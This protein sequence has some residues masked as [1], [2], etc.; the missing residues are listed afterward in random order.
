[1]PAEDPNNAT[2]PGVR[3]H[4]DAILHPHR[5]LP[6]RGWTVVMGVVGA[7]SLTIGLV[8]MLQG[9]WPVMGFL[10]LDV[11]LVW[12]AFRW[13]YRSAELYETVRLTDEAL[14]VWRIDPRH[15]PRAWR[16]EP[17][18][19]RVGMDDPPRH[20]SQVTLSSHGQSLVIGAFLTPDER[21]AFAKT[22]RAALAD[23]R[24]TL[25]PP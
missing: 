13:N 23:W 9:A 8:F 7:A 25:P 18:W 15:E 1:M 6:M 3:V 17:T 4:F 16:F 5:S 21:L 22:L 2:H 20:T 19:L 24:R 10:G 12:L 11:L 14:V